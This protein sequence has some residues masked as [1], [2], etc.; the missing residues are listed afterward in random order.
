VGGHRRNWARVTVVSIVLTA[1][2]L[3]GA[4]HGG[5]F[6][7]PVYLSGAEGYNIYRIPTIVKAANGDLLAFAEARAGG[8]ASEID[9]VVK[10]STNAGKTWGPL[11]VVKDSADF[12]GFF[13]PGDAPPITVGN[14]SPVVDLLDPVHP[15]RIWLPFTLE[16][17]RVFVAY[18]DDHGKSWSDHVEIT[19]TAKDPS[20]NWYATGPVHGIQLMRGT[21]AGRLIIPSDHNANGGAAQGAH[22]LY[23]DDHGQSWKIGAVDTNVRSQTTSSPNETLAV[24]L[25]DGRVYYN[26]RDAHTANPGN[27]SIAYSSDGGLNFDPPQFVHDS[28]IT[29]PVVQNSAVRFRATDE[30]DAENVILYSGPGDTT[31]RRNLTIRAS[32]DE[33]ASW[34]KTT[35]IHSGPAAYSDLVKLNDE[36]FG[37]LF[38]GG[39]SLYN[40]ILFAYMDYDDLDP[41]PWNGVTGDV[42]QDGALTEADVSAFAAA[43]N[44]LSNEFFL[45]GVDSYENGDLNF[46]G[47][48]TL[49]DV[50]QLRQALVASGVSPAGL[51]RLMQIPEPGSW[52]LAVM[53][54]LS[55]LARRFI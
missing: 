26:A 41:A 28:R 8:D 10:R 29:S 15:G 3:V 44:P 17:D 47:R 51:T 19:A 42:D 21:V 9:V 6:K 49:A 1:T 24:E 25:V 4:C 38:E 53:G 32:L 23:S 34:T 46:D 18:S 37:V 2:V 27:R 7:V 16:N 12:I 43:W 33:T 55:Q 36:K 35:V 45:G 48:I 39:A 13:P 54:M 14:Q 31:S 20:W 11:S 52:Q 40:E 50:F 30:G 22:S 5:V